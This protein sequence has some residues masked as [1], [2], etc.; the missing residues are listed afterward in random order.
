MSVNY[1]MTKESEKTLRKSFF[2]FYDHVHMSWKKLADTY[3]RHGTISDHDLEK[4]FEYEEQS[5]A[6]ESQMLEE[7]I[8]HIS[9]YSPFASHLRFIISIIYSISDL[10]RMADYVISNARYLNQHRI[11]EKSIN[12]VLVNTMS[13]SVITMDKIVDILRKRENIDEHWITTYRLTT[14]YAEEFKKYFD[15][16]VRILVKAAYNKDT[17]EE[18]RNLI[19]GTSMLLKNVERNVD[20]ATNIVENFVYIKNA[21]FFKNK[22]SKQSKKI[23]DQMSDMA[24]LIEKRG[25]DSSSSRKSPKKTKRH[26]K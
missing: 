4:F 11:K 20:H 15:D 24:T 26:K 22:R 13:K 7:C 19:A 23:N 14:K 9:R 6:F 16:Q 3:K 12:A 8:W 2:N 10:E 1:S 25:G 5:N 17:P 21:D 18:A